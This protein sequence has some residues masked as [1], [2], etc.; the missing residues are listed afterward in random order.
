MKL[1]LL[2]ILLLLPFAAAFAERGDS[3]D[4]SVEAAGNVAFNGTNAPYYHVA[5]RQGLSSISPNSG[6]FRAAVTKKM[7]T[8]KR[9][10]Y[11]GAV[12]LVG[13]AGFSSPFIVQQAYGELQFLCFDLM[14]GSKEYWGEMRNPSLS[15]GGM[16]W[17][18]NARPIPQ[19]RVGIFEFVEFPWTNSWLQVKLDMSYGRFTDNRYLRDEFA[20]N[21]KWFYTDDVYYHQKK[22]FFRSKEDRN[23]I[24]TVG[25][26]FAAQFGGTQ[27]Y[28]DKLT[29]QWV[30][31]ESSLKVKDFWGVFI[32]GA[33]DDESAVGDQVYYYGNHLGAWHAIAEYKFQDR[34]RLKGYFEWF[35]DDGSGMGKLNGWDGLWGMEYS[36]GK[37]GIVSDIL[38]E[39]LQ[40]TNQSGP[41]HWNPND[42]P[43]THVTDAN[44]TGADNYY[45]NY[46]YV[47]WAHWGMTNG[48]PLIASPAYN[49]D[50][51]LCFTN[52]RVQAFHL[53]ISGQ[54]K[55]EW[56]YR[57][58]A[59]YRRTWGT[60]YI[61]IP[62]PLYST[63]A[64][65]EVTYSPSKLKGWSFLASCAFDIGTLYDSNSGTA[66]RVRKTGNLFSY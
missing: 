36:F 46:Y 31:R 53:G 17:S 45:N 44:A 60:P 37:K 54:I 59:S 6:Y 14:V 22:I 12:D 32:P 42:N 49:R 29:E 48:T 43:G 21:P 63:S 40:T 26:E 3:I 10:D 15:S 39:Y 1:F 50:G 20:W 55:R 62:S 66:L 61:P 41:I 2:N 11:G 51:Y 58:L 27:H 16:V 56:D 23:F 33:G 47:G 28:F 57:L 7:N 8:Q 5:N 25:A 18:G 34:S 4:Y 30:T 65:V 64:M 52:N 13:A 38:F 9:F 24:M 35:W 19:V